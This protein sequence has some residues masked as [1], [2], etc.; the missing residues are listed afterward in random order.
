MGGAW[1]A[2]LKGGAQKALLLICALCTSESPLTSQGSPYLRPPP[3]S[4][5]PLCAQNQSWPGDGQ[6]LMTIQCILF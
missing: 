2:L 6:E 4:A 3:L 1:L 5:V